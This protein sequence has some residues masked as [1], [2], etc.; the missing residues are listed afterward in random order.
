MYQITRVQIMQTEQVLFMIV[1]VELT[2]LLGPV[3]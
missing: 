3:L 2:S 1:H